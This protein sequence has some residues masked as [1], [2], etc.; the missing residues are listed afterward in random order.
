MSSETPLG[1]L[2]VIEFAGLAPGPFAGMILADWGAEVIR[3]DRP[4][5]EHGNTFT[6]D[7]LTRHKRSIAINLK[8]PSGLALAK[9]LIE[10]ADVLIDPFRPDVLEKL[11]LGPDVFLGDDG[12]NKRL[13]YARLVGFSRSG[14][15]AHLAGHDL[16]YLALGGV[17][18]LLPGTSSHPSFPLNILADFAGGGMMCAFGILI[19]LYERNRNGGLGQVVENDMVSGAR[20]LS[21]NPLLASF[22][23]ASMSNPPFADSDATSASRMHNTLDGGAP[24]YNLYDCA[25]GRW[26]SVACI[27]PKFYKIFLDRFLAALPAEFLHGR[28]QDV[29]ASHEQ[30]NRDRWPQTREFF[31]DGF[32]CYSREHWERVFAGSDACTFPVLSPR[33]ATRLASSSAAPFVHPNLS[34]SKHV[35]LSSNDTDVLHP[36]EHKDA[37]LNELGITHGERAKLERDGAFGVQKGRPK[38]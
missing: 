12:T 36:G 25:D 8:V 18:S 17:L 29:S 28:T 38:L 2:K 13:I 1:G 14:P 26:M 33:E 7:I 24:F 5:S 10:S 31:I 6:G 22:A 30:M 23:H 3:L 19:A 27:E 11:G 15:H 9:R 32:A 16:N 20:Y 21:T 35:P 37:I 4:P 34:R